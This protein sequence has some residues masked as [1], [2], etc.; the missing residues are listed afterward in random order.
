MS[1]AE[2]WLLI[3]RKAEGGAE[4]SE[5]MQAWADANR[6]E[7]ISVSERRPEDRQ[8]VNFVAKM[9]SDHANVHLH[10]YTFGG[11]YS[12]AHGCFFV[13][14]MGMSASHWQPMPEPLK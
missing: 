4:T 2:A 14:G 3:W 10:G 6:P 11:E 12:A 9:E 8:R 5:M 1:G 7:W 13:P